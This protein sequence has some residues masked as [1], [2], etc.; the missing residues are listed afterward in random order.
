[1][2]KV[3]SGPVAFSGLAPSTVAVLGEA[4]GKVE[5]EQRQPFVGPSGLLIRE[6]MGDIG[7]DPKLLAWTNV[8]HCFPNRTPTADE[9]NACR[10]NVEAE[11]SFIH[12]FFC[13]VLGGVAV[14]HFHPIRIGEIRGKWWRMRT[15][16]DWPWA[17]ATW[18]P[19]AALRNADLIPEMKR[20]LMM[21]RLV[22][23]G[24]ADLCRQET[25]V[26]CGVPTSYRKDDIAWCL[27]HSP[28]A[29]AKGVG[30]GRKAGQPSRRTPRD[31]S[32]SSV[33]TRQGK[34]Q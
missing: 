29:K 9:V 18:H 17:M 3:G 20:D 2:C 5:D 28:T 27:R 1:M 23:E 19:A 26:K 21:F 6:L 32:G 7:L 33:N 13:L 24:K 10:G 34:L 22:V 31:D 25:C 4:P 11:L 16:R 15:I 8:V 12:P 30:G 14:S